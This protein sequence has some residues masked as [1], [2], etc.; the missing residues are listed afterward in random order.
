MDR[1]DLLPPYVKAISIYDYVKK[2]DPVRRPG[3]GNPFYWRLTES[4]DGMVRYGD[5]YGPVRLQMLEGM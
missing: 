5:I 1:F 3:D 4:L 2:I